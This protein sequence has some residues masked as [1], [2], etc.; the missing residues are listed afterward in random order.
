MAE[1]ARIV[2][3]TCARRPFHLVRALYFQGSQAVFWDQPSPRNVLSRPNLKF[4]LKHMRAGDVLLLAR[5]ADIWARHGSQDATQR[6]IE[7]QGI[8]VIHL[9]ADLLNALPL[10]DP[11]RNP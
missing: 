10:T 9:I 6:R 3:Y 7:N 1:T 11:N 8:K 2:G 4:A 5:K